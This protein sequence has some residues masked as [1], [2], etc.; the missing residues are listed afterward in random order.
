MIRAIENEMKSDIWS[1]LKAIAWGVFDGAL[2]LTTAGLGIIITIVKAT[3]GAIIDVVNMFRNVWT[4][5][6]VLAEAK[7][8][9]MR[10]KAAD[11][12]GSTDALIHRDALGFNRWF[13]TVCDRSTPLAVLCLNSGL[14]TNL[15]AMLNTGDPTRTGAQLQQDFDNT[16]SAVKFMKQHGKRYIANSSLK[17][18]S[19]DQLVNQTVLRVTKGGMLGAV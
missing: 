8:H 10:N 18:V 7:Q 13:S 6:A 11:S 1:G 9:W 12:G 5:K 14:C 2:A 3:I 15:F 17:F 19:K 16:H 4:A